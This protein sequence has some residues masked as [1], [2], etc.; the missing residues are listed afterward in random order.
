MGPQSLDRVRNA[1]WEILEIAFIRVLYKASAVVVD[2]GDSGAAVEHDGPFGSSVPVQFSNS[3]CLR[4]HVYAG[5]IFRDGQHAL[6]NLARP[7]A[8]VNALIGK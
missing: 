3:S 5:K 7:S 6:G 2:R 1:G 8:L 4:S